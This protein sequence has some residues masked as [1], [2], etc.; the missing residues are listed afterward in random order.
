MSQ[1]LEV[2]VV[3]Y[4]LLKFCSV[5][6]LLINFYGS[7][8][9]YIPLVPEVTRD[10]YIGLSHSA[11]CCVSFLIPSALSIFHTLLGNTC[12]QPKP[13]ITRPA[14]VSSYIVGTGLGTW[15]PSFPGLLHMCLRCWRA[16]SLSRFLGI[17]VPWLKT[18]AHASPSTGLEL[19]LCFSSA[20]GLLSSSPWCLLN[21]AW[22]LSLCVSSQL[23][24]LPPLITVEAETNSI[25]GQLI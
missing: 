5:L 12:N 20:L 15:L 25:L 10:S 24:T 11:S 18:F 16:P 19:G 3:T 2:H 23:C 7:W 13:E 8:H 21:L 22:E 17:W 6:L 9:Y 1:T 4:V 14:T